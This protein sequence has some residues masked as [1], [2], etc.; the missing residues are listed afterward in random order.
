MKRDALNRIV[1]RE[2]IGGSAYKGLALRNLKM[3]L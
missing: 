1:M 3:T 2:L